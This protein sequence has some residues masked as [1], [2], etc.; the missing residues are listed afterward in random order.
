VGER[1]N[2]RTAAAGKQP[3][4]A[5]GVGP[6]VGSQRKRQPLRGL[7]ARLAFT[8]SLSVREDLLG[9]GCCQSRRR[10][11]GLGAE[12]LLVTL[13]QAVAVIT[14]RVAGRSTGARPVR[15]QGEFHAQ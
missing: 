10:T 7:G 1:V 5:S 3:H 13:P 8:T 12:L 9:S 15:A 4:C 11:E 2:W 6:E 14:H